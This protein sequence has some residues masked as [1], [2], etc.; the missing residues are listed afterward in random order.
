MMTLPREGTTLEIDPRV[1]DYLETAFPNVCPGV[2]T[3]TTPDKLTAV[4]L[5]VA[6]MAGR[7]DVINTLKGINLNTKKD[8]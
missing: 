3:E 6:R 8:G 7:Q 1:I 2:P 5:Q 4:A